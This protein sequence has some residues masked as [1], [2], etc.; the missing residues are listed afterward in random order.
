MNR[1]YFYISILFFIPI[2]T[3]NCENE[4]SINYE[5]FSSE[6]VVYGMIDPFA[7]SNYIRIGRVFYGANGI[8][9]SVQNKD[10]I[11][12]DKLSASIEFTD[13]EYVYSSMILEEFESD[14]SAGFF[15]SQRYPTYYCGPL[16]LH[17]A[18]F[19][20]TQEGF[21][22]LKLVITTEEKVEP[23]VVLEKILRQP[24][25][26]QPSKF[27]K[28]LRLYSTSNR[29][30]L[31]W[32]PPSDAEYHEVS[33]SVYFSELINESIL[34]RELNWSYTYPI[35]EVDGNKQMILDGDRFMR[36]ISL[37][38]SQDSVQN[39]KKLKSITLSFLS[40]SESIR[41][42][43]SSYQV[44]ADHNGQPISN[45]INGLGVFGVYTKSEFP[46]LELTSQ[47]IDSLTNGRFTRHLRFVKY[48]IGK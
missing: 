14:K 31:I 48:D 6:V 21:T 26:I 10:S 5:P 46:G 15:N 43:F 13:L 29:S 9:E 28:Q 24:V 18:S 39:V 25:V 8:M 40:G 19:S 33:L 4:L 3:Q 36:N 16:P 7:D 47:G 11:Y 2:L 23:T 27:E 22:Y 45:V 30:T 34:D 42:Y 20:P 38:L 44:A 37:K 1:T 12:F 35:L 32:N 17:T 41:D